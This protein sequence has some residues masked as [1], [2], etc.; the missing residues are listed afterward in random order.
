MADFTLLTRETVITELRAFPGLLSLVPVERIFGMA[1]VEDCPYPFTRYGVPIIAAYNA[2]C[3][4]GS[5]TEITLHAFTEGDSEDEVTA[6]CAEFVACL[7]SRHIPVPVPE[8]IGE[9]NICF[10][11][12]GGQVMMDPLESRVWHGFRIFDAEA[13]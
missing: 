1:Q 6:I 13:I 5:A 10:R 2:S 9:V 7:D 4:A 11:W 3:I 12:T 8:A